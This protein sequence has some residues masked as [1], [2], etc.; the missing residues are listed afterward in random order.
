MTRKRAI[1]LGLGLMVLG[2]VPT[3][4]GAWLD[5]AQAAHDW[6]AAFAYLATLLVGA[7]YVLMIGHA[8]NARWFV[9][10]RRPCELTVSAM[11]LLLVLVVPLLLWIPEIYP[12][13][14]TLA[15]IEEHHFRV[16]VERK[17]AWLNR[18]AFVGRSVFYLVVLAL[19]SEAL[20]RASLRQDRGHDTRRRM[21]RLSCAGIPLL[22]LVVTAAAFDWLMSVEP[23]WYST[24]FGIY[25]WAGGFVAALGLL[26]I[27]M[28]VAPLPAEVGPGHGHAVGRLVLAFTIFWAYCAY[29]QLV[30]M[31]IADL[32]EEVAW[33]AAR[34]DGGW[35]GVGMTL[36][37]VHF[38]VPF[39]VL[40]SKGLKERRTAL[41]AVGAWMVVAHYVDIYWLVLPALHPKDFSPHWLDVTTPLALVGACVALAAWRAG[42]VEAVPVADPRLPESLAY[43]SQ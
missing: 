18:P 23:Y 4:V 25:A 6:L 14:G 20:V 22:S 19:V 30:L 31:W 34:V 24:L 7:L 3:A 2:G 17:L 42:G 5:P 41:A 16:L 32:P 36:L 21:Y 29:S 26:A 28:R 9:A 38:F 10:L 15:E 8:C 13:H 27:L 33:W 11:P 43:E 35:Y 40:L 37:V 12:W 39:L 1:L